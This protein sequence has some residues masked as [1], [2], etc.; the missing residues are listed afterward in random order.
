MMI[1]TISPGSRG[2][3]A[4][5]RPATAALGPAGR[6][7][8]IL[9]QLP[10]EIVYISQRSFVDLIGQCHGYRHVRMPGSHMSH[11]GFYGEDQSEVGK[12][13]LERVIKPA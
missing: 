4:A 12:T 8:A 3:L 7:L 1:N 11:D 13:G 10:G 2:S 6:D 5:S 9:P